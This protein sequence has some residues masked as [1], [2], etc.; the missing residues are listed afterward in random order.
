MTGWI[1]LIVRTVIVVGFLVGVG[2][3]YDAARPKSKRFVREFGVLG[4]LYLAGPL[5]AVLIC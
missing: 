3:T 1:L 5:V 2:K 4:V